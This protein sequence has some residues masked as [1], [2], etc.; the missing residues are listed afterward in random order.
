MFDGMKFLCL[1]LP[2]WVT[3]PGANAAPVAAVQMSISFCAVGKNK[4][5]GKK[6][7]KKSVRSNLEKST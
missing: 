6:K 2:L 7:K 4:Q 5:N 1:I 3:A